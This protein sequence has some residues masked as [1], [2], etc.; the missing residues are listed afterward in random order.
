MKK[1]TIYIVVATLCLNFSSIAQVKTLNL[2]GKIIDENGVPVAGINLS[3][4]DTKIH[5]VT[6]KDGIF[7]LLNVQS[8]STLKISGTGYKTK[9]LPNIQNWDLHLM[10]V[11]TDNTYLKEVEIVSTGYQSVPKD[12][13]T[14]SFSQ[15]DN[16]LINRSVSTN[17]LDRL[18]GVA[19]GVIFNK[20]R[21]TD[22]PNNSLITIRG[23]S[24]IFGNASPLIVIDNFPYDG[25][26]NNINPS[27]I[28]TMTILKDASAASAWGA[29]SGNG[30]IVITTKQG[31]LNTAPIIS[32]NVSSTI[33]EKP[34][35]YYSPQI[36]S[37]QFIDAEQF[38]FN[39]GAFDSYFVDGFSAVSPAVSIFR[40]K[41][42]FE[43]N[44][45]DSLSA[46]SALKGN[47]YRKQL[48]KYFYRNSINQQYQASITGGSDS[49]KYFV[50]AGFDQNKSSLVDNDYNRITLNA[51]NT[52]YFLQKRLEFFSNI[53]YT[54]SQT[55]TTN[56][57]VSP[58]PYNL[59]ADNNGTSLPV[60]NIISIPYANT[61]GN[62][63]L[64]DWLYKP[65]DELNNH[66]STPKTNSTDYRINL[67][68]SYNIKKGLKTSVLYGYEKAI[69]DSRTL[70]EANSYYA[71]NLINTYSRI[72]PATDELTYPV[73]LGSILDQ[74]SSH[75]ES[76]NGRVQIGY[77]NNWDNHTLSVIAGA[78][79][80]SLK[81]D[82]IFTRFYGYNPQT[83]TNQ[84]S[85]I[86]FTALNPFFYGSNSDRIGI[87]SGAS[88]SINNNLSYYFNGSYTLLKKYI[89]SLSARK[90]ESNIFGV[91]TNQKG[92]PLWSAGLAWAI[93][94]EHFYRVSWL[95]GL[96]L[97]STFGYTGNV[98]NNLSAYLTAQSI[99]SVNSYNS[100]YSSII[101][102]PNP[103]LRWE[104]IRN[105]NFGLDF[106]ALDNRLTGSF[107][108]WQ[109]KGIDLIGN[110]PIAPQ[111]GIVL[112]TGNSANTFT[113][114][115]D[116]QINSININ[117]A[118]KWY[119][120]L[121]Y[122]YTSSKVTDYKVSNGTNLDIVSANYNN[123][124]KGYPYYSIFSFRYGGL[125]SQGNPIGYLNGN[126]SN[127]YSKI[128]NSSNREELVYNGS[129]TPTSFGSL[130]NT[131]LFR[132]FDFSFV[133]SYR[134][135]YYFRRYSLDNGALYSTVYGGGYES[136]T[137]YDLRWQ[138]SG[139]EL[140]T[141]VP[142]LIF[143]ADNSRD[144]LYK[145]SEVLVEKAD[146]IRL[147]DVRLGYTFSKR[148]NL[149]LK[150][151]NIF[152]Y[153]NNAGIIWRANRFHL[154]PDYPAGIPAVKTI[155]IGLK[156]DL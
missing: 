88:N 86:D 46:I 141:N 27:D 14:G 70:N 78:E 35:L 118:V 144:N 128:S 72:D 145:Y 116:V 55:K 40:S 67:S 48:S 146:N 151:L 45:V 52:Y 39:K 36:S 133:L 91:S 30:V 58:T 114:G 43:I 142:S 138:K 63:K 34:N 106:R 139:D 51:S 47:D 112:Y 104:K 100:P 22:L 131:F 155:A 125:D 75:L 135:G 25:D 61:A 92:V 56:T 124:L 96:K 83:L 109:K 148:N 115:V 150:N 15:V 143:P 105:I 153:L 1:L 21:P 33:G 44:Q 120:T 66:Y 81:T 136:N 87:G 17:I 18:D 16:T 65:L 108:Y 76:H 101:N 137:D 117:K 69:T 2:K 132:N 154:D 95:Q 99:G 24:T 82:N 103:S 97:R 5:T 129:A 110:S 80:R 90:D 89:I 3:I 73:P 111:T 23:R 127:N 79:I 20:N 12:R 74:A 54:G 123:P 11:Q 6:N 31:R 50:S 102:P 41:K 32:F 130:R 38:L 119:T 8:G 126:P 19:S 4:N 49:Q 29:R 77:D 68:L 10:V 121:I 113:K 147:Q 71:R 94:K 57:Y 152:L 7:D 156:T 26:I 140:K 59:L 122:N 134:L 98:S 85:A 28:E 13:A 42:N 107:D 149:P 64:L 62:G 84:N 53:I 60:A 9:Q 93:D 37:V